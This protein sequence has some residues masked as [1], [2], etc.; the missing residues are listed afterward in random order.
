MEG[1]EWGRVERSRGQGACSAATYWERGHL[2][3]C[4][5]AASYSA[6]RPEQLFRASTSS[7][8]SSDRSGFRNLPNLRAAPNG[9]AI[10]KLLDHV[11]TILAGIL[12]RSGGSLLS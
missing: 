2:A 12:D 8:G 3:G 1:K 4:A 9:P 7:H 6:N 5:A 10:T 11:L